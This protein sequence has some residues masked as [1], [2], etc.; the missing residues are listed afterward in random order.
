MREIGAGEPFA[1][2][3]K[4]YFWDEDVDRQYRRVC[5]HAGRGQVYVVRDCTAG[6][7]PLPSDIPEER[8]FDL[9]EAALESYG[10]HNHRG[11]WFCADYPLYLFFLHEPDYA[12]LVSVEYDV[13]VFNDLEPIVDAMSAD[14]ID[15]VGRPLAEENAS[16]N[17]IRSCD[18]FYPLD[19]V[20]K[21]LCCIAFH[22]RRAVAACFQARLEH[23]RQ[24]VVGDLQTWPISEV[25]FPTE[26]KRRGW[27]TADIGGFCDHLD[28]YNWMN[29]VTEG[30]VSHL[31]PG[32]TF[33]HPLTNR[34]KATRSTFSD[35][36]VFFTPDLLTHAVAAR[37]FEFFC[38]LYHL[39]GNAPHERDQIRAAMSS[40]P[41]GL[42]DAPGWFGRHVVGE[43]ER[44][45]Q[46]SLSPY[47]RGAG[48]AARAF[49]E[50]PRFGFSFHTDL[51]AHPWWL[52]ELR[53]PVWASALHLM[54][55]GDV[56]RSQH[57]CIEAGMVPDAMEIVWENRDGAPIPGAARGGLTVPLH[58]V[59]RFVRV[60]LRDS[61]MLHFDTLVLTA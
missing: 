44:C 39:P 18:G 33:V 27:R 25:I 50:I 54:D 59:V 60:F 6:D 56:H 28:N 49:G 10:L 31:R 11:F 14:G 21:A 1:V 47:S 30:F 52:L 22:S 13:G 4:V 48:E 61:S 40:A 2:L 57:L 35:W 58:R 23:N 26:M 16:W 37:D 36:P 41:G 55:R 19:Q 43:A 45:T 5:R 32:R 17:F 38:R 7:Y 29:G 20:E 15:F 8:I 51:E 53:E 9:N 24:R 42:L 3:F 34:R 46:S 12:F